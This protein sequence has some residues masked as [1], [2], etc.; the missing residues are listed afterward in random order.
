MKKK[1]HIK[2]YGCQMNVYDSQKMRDLM[3]SQGYEETSEPKDADLIII[4]TCNIRQKPTDK[5]F[6]ELGK[7]KPL[8]KA[9]IANGEYMVIVVAGCVAQAEGE[10]ILKRMKDVDIVLGTESY[11]KLPEIIESVLQ[12]KKQKVNLDFETKEKFSCLNEINTNPTTVTAFLTIQEGCDKF[13]SYCVVPYTR[14]RE[15]SRPFKDIVNE[16][17]K[18]VNSGVKEITLLGQNVD[19]YKGCDENGNEINLAKII[20]RLAKIENLKRIRYMTSYPSEIDEELIEAHGNEPKL[21]PFIHLPMQSGS[22]KVLK[23]MNRRYTPEVYWDIVQ[24]LRKAR[25]DIAISSDFIIGFV[26][27]EE[28]DF[29]ETMDLV[30]KVKFA[31]SFSFKY[32]IRPNTRGEKMEG[33]IP[34]DIKA[35]RLAKFQDL[36][37]AQQEEFNQQMKGRVT[38][39][40]VENVLSDGTGLFGKTPY[41]QSVKIKSPKGDGNGEGKNSNE[42]NLEKY[43]GEIL[44]V[45]INK[46]S[47]KGLVGEMLNSTHSK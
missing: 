3:I 41:L 17:E 13:C 44:K 21:M 1:L 38:E 5:I 20:K 40:L 34:E 19:C 4:N 26:G 2:T 39:V 9:K 22:A 31:Q 11:H 43:V 25:P 23:N 7:L 37:D 29:Q 28:N 42:N 24:K 10:K 30:K 27:E 18:L 33:H 45:K 6:S 8:K 15:C 46:V 12:D 14:G 16:A 36:T 47:M 35:E 32:S